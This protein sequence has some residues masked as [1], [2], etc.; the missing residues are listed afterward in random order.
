MPPWG[1]NSVFLSHGQQ[2]TKKFSGKNQT[3]R[4]HKRQVM[5]PGYILSS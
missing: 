4:T 3:V 1:W 5:G 2:K